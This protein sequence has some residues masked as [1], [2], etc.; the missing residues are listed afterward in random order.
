[1]PNPA[2]AFAAE[3][4]SESAATRRLLERV[5]SDKLAWK[6]HPKSMSLG[7]LALHVARIPGRMSELANQDGLDASKVSFEPPAPKDAAELLPILESGLAS[8]HSLLTGLNDQR[9]SAPWKMSFGEREVFSVPRIGMIRSMMLNH[10]YHHRGQ[11]AV[12][13]RILDVPV[14]ATYGRSADESLFGNA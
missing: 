2:H 14:P 7:Q 11:L 4:Q 8:A 3:L 5:P 1:M 6:P 12:Y 9:A 10:L 13:L